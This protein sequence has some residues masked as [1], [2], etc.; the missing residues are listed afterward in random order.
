MSSNST[1][2]KPYILETSSN[3][4]IIITDV[5]AISQEINGVS[6]SSFKIGKSEIRAKQLATSDWIVKERIDA[7]AFIERD[8]RGKPFL[9]SMNRHISISHTGNI[10]G[11][12]HHSTNEVS[13][14]L[15]YYQRDL[16]KIQSRF[17]DDREISIM[18]AHDFTN[19]QILIWSIKECLFKILGK[20]GIKF[21]SELKIDASF[22]DDPLLRTE[23][24]VI[25]RG[26][27]HHYIAKSM[28]FEDLLVSYIDE[29]H[30]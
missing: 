16:T 2:L 13:I 29:P 3:A 26:L 25:H 15:E 17:T 12:I 18:E 20:Q 4:E 11:L 27:I 9:N 19:P 5:D 30:F 10:L 1:F 6:M 7:N 21:S 22:Y 24:R 8:T 23:C 14:D 28:I